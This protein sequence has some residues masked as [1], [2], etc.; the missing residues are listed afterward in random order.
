MA[1]IDLS[2]I[3]NQAHEQSV[4]ITKE[5]LKVQEQ[6]LNQQFISY[7]N[8]LIS[9]LE[10]AAVLE[11]NT[12]TLEKMA[13]V[14]LNS[15]PSYD[16]MRNSVNNIIANK[17]GYDA[18]KKLTMLTTWYQQK[19]IS[20]YGGSIQTKVIIEFQ[21]KIKIATLNEEISNKTNLIEM[22]DSLYHIDKK[23]PSKGG[24]L[25]ARYN[26]SNKALTEN[27]HNIITVDDITPLEEAYF[28]I[29]QRAD[30]MKKG[31]DGYGSA[32]TVVPVKNSNGEILYY[33][34]STLGDMKEAYLNMKL[35]NNVP[36]ASSTEEYIKILLDEATTNVT[37]TAG[38]FKGDFSINID[39]INTEIAAKSQGASAMGILQALDYAYYLKES[40]TIGGSR[41]G[42]IDINDIVFK[43][44]K[45]KNQSIENAQITDEEMKSVLD[46]I[47]KDIFG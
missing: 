14:Q 24:G 40:I 32:G 41:G 34:L 9:E 26:T 30:V 43:Q 19:L 7:I 4:N 13:N 42:Q 38:L 44:R 27:K 23:A 35:S 25:T 33:S 28:K 29:L 11:S 37:N 1:G 12:T 6:T 3:V 22:F 20:L 46:Q 36:S 15:S 5:Q 45:D 16:N 2:P 18:F 47:L 21:G 17:Y 39:G 8:S 31:K 10:S